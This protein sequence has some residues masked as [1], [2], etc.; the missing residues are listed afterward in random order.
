MNR[1]GQ[2]AVLR[3]F[4]TEGTAGHH[5]NLKKGQFT[6]PGEI[7]RTRH[8]ISQKK[9]RVHR[10]NVIQGC[11]ATGLYGHHMKRTLSTGTIGK[12]QEDFDSYTAQGRRQE[13]GRV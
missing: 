6:P 11:T 1:K 12:K 5:S 13:A 7:S 10:K 9:Q 8:G 4:R 2:N 3:F